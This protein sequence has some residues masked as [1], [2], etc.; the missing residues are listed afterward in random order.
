M[1]C[2]YCESI[3]NDPAVTCPV[4]G[5]VLS[6]SQSSGSR[7]HQPS[8]GDLDEPAKTDRPEPMMS[9]GDTSRTVQQTPPVQP[10]LNIR[11]A[12]DRPPSRPA[13]E[14]KAP[15]AE[16][17]KKGPS[18]LLA[19]GYDIKKLLMILLVI[20]AAGYLL[21]DYYRSTHF[22]FEDGMIGEWQLT[23]V[24]IDSEKGSFDKYTGFANSHMTIT[25]DSIEY[26]M[27]KNTYAKVNDG[28]S[29][30]TIDSDI[31]KLSVKKKDLKYS[32]SAYQ[33]SNKT[34]FTY[35]GGKIKQRV[36]LEN[37]N[38]IFIWEKK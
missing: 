11:P 18:F 37:E 28:E 16:P 6:S 12:A 35:S 3:V 2:P 4:C 19:Y 29:E 25:K 34:S 15:V 21:Y 13:S 27:S 24:E 17:A 33:Y 31:T 8:F 32:N 38:A 7:W 23:A 14:N 30:W 36:K 1:K 9:F 22:D 20:A 26:N 5:S 10:N